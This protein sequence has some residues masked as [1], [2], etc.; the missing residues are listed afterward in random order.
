MFLKERVT[1]RDRGFLGSLGLPVPSFPWD[2]TRLHEPE[3]LCPSTNLPSR[4]GP[5]TVHWVS[6]TLVPLGPRTGVGG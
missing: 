5:S 1:R 3:G 2:S 6:V 4:V